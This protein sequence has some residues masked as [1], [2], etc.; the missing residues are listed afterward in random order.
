MVAVVALAF[1]A[2]ILVYVYFGVIPLPSL[3]QTGFTKAQ[4]LW[5]TIPS[6]IQNIIQIGIPTLFATFFAWTKVRAMDKLQQTKLQ[7]SQ[8]ITQL[9]GEKGV[10]EEQVKQSATSG[11][12]GLIKSRDEAQTLVTKYKQDI[13]G[14]EQQMRDM[15]NR[16][17]GELSSLQSRLDKYE[18]K[19][20]TKVL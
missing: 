14:Y 16:H 1:C 4:A 2:A 6:T 13:S 19:V 3:L 12:E 8:T 11:V 10:L 9:E 18:P 17:L 5:A 15:Q 7:A 20:V